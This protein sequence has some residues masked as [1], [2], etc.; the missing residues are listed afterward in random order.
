M[1]TAVAPVP[2]PSTRERCARQDREQTRRRGDVPMRTIRCPTSR[3][4][5]VS[6]VSQALGSRPGAGSTRA[7]SPR[8][9]RNRPMWYGGAP[10]QG[11]T[12]GSP[13]GS[14][15][16]RCSRHS[17]SGSRDT[18]CGNGF[19]SRRGAY[20]R[21]RVAGARK[22]PRPWK[23]MA[24]AVRFIDSRELA[25][26]AQL[27]KR[28][29]EYVHPARDGLSEPVRSHLFCRTI[30]SRSSSVPR[31]CTSAVCGRLWS[32]EPTSDD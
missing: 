31:A 27:R 14:G 4:R 26:Y 23:P 9:L 20:V 29:D 18:S 24:W 15:S 30:M 7:S 16:L 17:A 8:W 1:H 32:G 11:V 13:K 19:A 10:L 5:P 28:T 21:G 2:H 12:R 6:D 22:Q 3:A 25:D